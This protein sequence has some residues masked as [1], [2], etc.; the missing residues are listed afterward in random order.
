MTATSAA[1]TAKTAAQKPT[2][3]P[4]GDA[5][6]RAEISPSTDSRAAAETAPPSN[7]DA[8]T[9][10][11]SPSTDSSD[12]FT[13]IPPSTD[14]D[15]LTKFSLSGA[16]PAALRNASVSPG[17]RRRISAHRDTSSRYLGRAVTPSRQRISV[18]R[19]TGIR[20]ANSESPI[21]ARAMCAVKSSLNVSNVANPIR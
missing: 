21:P 3:R 10:E 13:E 4:D 16:N 7:P 9:E 6:A 20:R 5:A 11:S 2:R 19:L 8:F 15:S 1:A 17:V 18:G 14:S 12:S